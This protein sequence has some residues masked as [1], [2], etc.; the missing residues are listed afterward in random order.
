MV[1]CITGHPPCYLHRQF[2]WCRWRINGIPADF[3][4]IL[5]IFFQIASSNTFR[6]TSFLSVHK[7]THATWTFSGS[8][9]FCSALHTSDW[10]S[11]RSV[12]LSIESDVIFHVMC[13]I[14]VTESL[15]LNNKTALLLTV[16][17]FVCAVAKWSEIQRCIVGRQASEAVRLEI[18]MTQIMR[19]ISTSSSHLLC[20]VYSLCS[21]FEWN[22]A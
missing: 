8:S 13:Q 6:T 2:S 20:T 4:L 17:S 18:M 12:V 3:W 9:Y 14:V 5:N 21:V 19:S 7:R 1:S 22:T 10:M 16:C 15:Y 11:C